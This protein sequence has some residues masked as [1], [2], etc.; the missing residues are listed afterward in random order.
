MSSCDAAA[1]KAASAAQLSP[2]NTSTS[3]SSEPGAGVSVPLVAQSDTPQDV[4]AMRRDGHDSECRNHAKG[5]ATSANPL[6][7]AESPTADVVGIAEGLRAERTW[8]M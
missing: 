5:E 3:S 7:F 6:A 2:A 8:M 4:T 1:M